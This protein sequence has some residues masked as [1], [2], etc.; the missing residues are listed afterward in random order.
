MANKARRRE[1]I[2]SYARMQ[3]YI[4]SG[5]AVIFFFLLH[6]TPYGN[7]IFFLIALLYL[8]ISYGREIYKDRKSHARAAQAMQEAAVASKRQSEIEARRANT[9]SLGY[10]ILSNYVQISGQ[11]HDDVDSV[12]ELLV[13]VD[14]DD[15]SEF[16]ALQ[17]DTFLETAEQIE[18]SLTFAG[19]LLDENVRVAGEQLIHEAAMNVSVTLQGEIETR[20]LLANQTVLSDIQRHIE[21]AG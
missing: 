4:Q 7:I 19:E 8:C 16:Q 3:L 6:A 12:F 11:N 21:K 2:R 10:H 5:M 9:D 15:L 1:V 18:N 13:S 17:I 14:M 20:K